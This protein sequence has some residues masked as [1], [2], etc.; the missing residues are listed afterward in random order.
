MPATVGIGLAVIA[1]AGTALVA[2]YA[3]RFD[4]AERAK[5]AQDDPALESLA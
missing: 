3:Y 2:R 1:I 4:L 5:R